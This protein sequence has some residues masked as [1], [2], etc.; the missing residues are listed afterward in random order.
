MYTVKDCECKLFL[1]HRNSECISPC[2]PFIE[3]RIAAGCA[4]PEETLREV[5][6]QISDAR[7]RLRVGEYMT[8]EDFPMVFKNDRHEAS[9]RKAIKN[10]AADNYD[11]TATVYLPTA[12]RKLW[13]AARNY[14]TK[15]NI[16]ISKI[17]KHQMDENAHTLLCAAKD[18]YLGTEYLTIRD[19]AD[20]IIVPDK[21]FGIIC[22][23]MA[24]HR[25]GLGVIKSMGGM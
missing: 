4:A 20:K 16:R 1:Y 15:D 12:D 11:L 14:I 24:I 5:L 25:F 13:N 10:T 19:M 6:S 23:A 21:I 18:L 2:C 7:F 9:F 3:E 17:K 22:N 8:Y